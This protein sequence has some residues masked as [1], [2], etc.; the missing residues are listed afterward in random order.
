MLATFLLLLL[1]LVLTQKT[2]DEKPFVM[3]EEQEQESNVFAIFM[4]MGMS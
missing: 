4:H 3:G 1:L 2:P